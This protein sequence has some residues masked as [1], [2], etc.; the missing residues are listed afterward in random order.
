MFFPKLDPLSR[1]LV[2]LP[3]KNSHKRTSVIPAMLGKDAHFWEELIQ[4]PHFLILW[5]TYC[6]GNA[7]YFV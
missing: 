6:I 3:G 5:P 2:A 1:G 4:Q 7:L